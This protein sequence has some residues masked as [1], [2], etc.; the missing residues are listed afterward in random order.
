MCCFFNAGIFENSSS[1][2]YSQP[3]LH[4]SSYMSPWGQRPV[5]RNRHHLVFK[6]TLLSN[7]DVLVPR[8]AVS[9][10]HHPPLLSS[11]P[12]LLGTEGNPR[13]WTD[14]LLCSTEVTHKNKPLI[15]PAPLVCLVYFRLRLGV[16]PPHLGERRIC[17]INYQKSNKKIN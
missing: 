15:A 5:Q 9:F 13:N 16:I 7:H 14:W 6:I 1:H 17:D 10:T 4:L 11:M 3:S 12:D 8:M 2:F